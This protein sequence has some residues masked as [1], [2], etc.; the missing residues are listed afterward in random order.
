MTCLSNKRWEVICVRSPILN[1]H[2][3]KNPKPRVLD[4]I[5][6]NGKVLLEVKKDKNNI[7]TLEWDDLVYQVNVAKD[8]SLNES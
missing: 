8:M 6:E 1:L 5:V 4:V 3:T 7:E 2:S